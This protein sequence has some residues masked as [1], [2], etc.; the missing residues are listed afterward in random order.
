MTKGIVH[1]FVQ[2]CR[3]FFCAKWIN[4]NFFLM[5]LKENKFFW[6][7]KTSVQNTPKIC[8]FRK[9]LVHGFCQN[10]RFF[11]LLFVWKMD[12]EKVFSECFERNE[13]FLGNKKICWKKPHICTFLKGLVHEFCLKMEFFYILFLH[14]IDQEKLFCKLSKEKKPFYTIKTSA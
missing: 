1:L 13:P 12:Q 7:I 14:K 4:K 5:F 11:Y 3:F 6:T 9:G 10:W 2:K 8:I